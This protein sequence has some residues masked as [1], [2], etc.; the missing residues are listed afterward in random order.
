MIGQVSVSGL[1]FFAGCSAVLDEKTV[2][3]NLQW[4]GRLD[5]QVDWAARWAGHLAE[6]RPGDPLWG[7]AA[8]GFPADFLAPGSLPDAPPFAVWVAAL[9][10]AVQ[11]WA[12]QP[13]WQGAVVACSADQAELALPYHRDDVFKPAL[14]HAL[15]LLLK[16]CDTGTPDIHTQQMADALQA[17]LKTVQ[18]QGWMP[19]TLRFFGAA[20]QRGIPTANRLG[21]LQLGQGCHT[22]LLDGSFTGHTSGLAGRLASSKQM[23]S[24]ILGRAALPVPAQH[25]AVTL[26]AA[27][28]AALALG[29]PVVVKPSNQ[30]QARGVM[31]GIRTVH[32]LRQAFAVAAAYSP[33]QVIV[34]KHID[35]QDHRM[36][37]VGGKLRIVTL[38][39][40]GGVVGDGARSVQIL[41]DALNADPRRGTEKDS[42]LLHIALD[43]QALDCL[44]EQSLTPTCV[45]APGRF[46]RLRQTANIST[47]GTAHDVTDHV[48]PDNRALAE[49]AAR[50]VGLDIAGVDFLCPD[51]SCSWREVGGAICEVNGQPAFRPH[52]L[53]TPD[54]DINGEV[55]DWLYQNKPSRIPTAAV[56]GT[57]G[58]NEVARL[59][60]HMW[61]AFGKTAGLCTPEGVW[62]GD[63]LV[64][65]DDLTGLDGVRLLLDDPATEAA[66]MVLT[67]RGL[68][69]A[70]NPCDCY[71]VVALLH[72]QADPNGQKDGGGWAQSADS[73][74]L[75]AQALARARHAVVINADDPLCLAMRERVRPGVRQILVA[76][77]ELHPAV[78]AHLAASGQAIFVAQVASEPW[79]VWA[80]GAA[81]TPLV[82]LAVIPDA[83]DGLQRTHD[84]HVLFAMALAGAQGLPWP[85]VCRAVVGFNAPC[86]ATQADFV[87]PSD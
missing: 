35:G 71:D 40:P 26:Q 44:A 67:M 24:Y 3:L 27:E 9:T 61:R 56:T 58:N 64:S 16:W 30:E 55:L 80:D 49:R 65:S 50:L 79:V 51:I 73:I 76:S 15:R 1:T 84:T 43:A 38:R 59:L 22:E 69:A 20:R 46:V 68:A 72:A 29:W 77:G 28:E 33:A 47:G 11:R 41:L 17:W 2:L 87:P 52:W 83:T 34:E 18:G 36:L 53:G 23:T 31:P 63:D 78:E 86:Q 10:V 4:T 60:H 54:R 13:V 85:T 81:Q 5:A 39:T 25:L 19:N 66:V 14:E 45:P 37:V 74:K 7:F 42:L 62:I 21:M 12:R 75:M 70:G 82:R 32:A 8:P 6:L 48:H 57:Y